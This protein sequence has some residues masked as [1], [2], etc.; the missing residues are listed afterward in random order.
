MKKILTYLSIFSLIFILYSCDKPAPTELVDDTDSELEVEV[1]TKDLNDQY[2]TPGSDTSGIT[3]GLTGLTNL[4]SV[5]G[6]KITKND[7]PYSFNLA[8]AFFFDKS[9]PVWYR[10]QRLL[11]YRTITP[12]T[13]WF[14]GLE[15]REVPF[16]IKYRDHGEQKDTLLGGKY[17]LYNMF[18]IGLPDQFLFHY[19]SN[20]TFKFLPDIGQEISFLI[21]TPPEIIGNVILEGSRSGGNFGAMLKWNAKNE[22]KISIILGL[23]KQGQNSS[24]PVYRFRTRDDGEVFIPPRLLNILPLESFEKVVVTFIR[25][26]EGYYENGN[27]DLL[28]SSQSIHSIFIDIP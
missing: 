20:V 11:A 9:K 18:N 28:V 13:I 6:I 16:R 23:T 21:P 1:I 24:I 27:N 4:I 8:Q 14:D 3:Q 19:N 2:Y 22:R 25:S 5:S 17:I 7:Q 26:Y 10:D 15:A 12:G